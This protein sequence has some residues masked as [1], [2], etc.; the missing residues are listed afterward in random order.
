MP[1]LLISQNEIVM[2]VGACVS[3]R[4]SRLRI[5]YLQQITQQCQHVLDKCVFVLR[6]ST[7]KK[8]L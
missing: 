3:H 8:C 1:I 5:R 2:Q 7:V 4:A 6:S